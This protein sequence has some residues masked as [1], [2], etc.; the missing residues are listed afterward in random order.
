MLCVDRLTEDTMTIMTMRPLAGSIE[1]F[2]VAQDRAHQRVIREIRRGV[3]DTHW[4]WYTFPSLRALG[5]SE[6]ALFYGIADLAEARAYL[7]D[8]QLRGRLGEY[9]MGV[10]Q[11]RRLMFGETDTRKLQA[12]MTL[13]R[14]VAADATLPDAVLAKFFGGKQDQRTLDVLAGKAIAPET[15]MGRV[16]MGRSWEKRI[17]QAQ[18][19]VASVGRRPE[20]DRP[21]DSDETRRF[22]N[23]FNLS[24]R[25]QRQIAAKW[26]EDR[27]RAREAGWDAHAD[28]VYY[29][30]H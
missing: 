27:E 28:S 30:E 15:A 17:A 4:M 24:E 7:N 12:C 2:R 3:K 9:T 22:L 11:Q 20:P 29:D 6:T 19:V 5:K 10:L 13:F 23:G 1:R 8:P 25:V 18:A 26:E 16:E 14:A 21:M